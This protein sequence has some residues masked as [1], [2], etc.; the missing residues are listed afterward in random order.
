MIVL[1]PLLTAGLVALSVPQTGEMVLEVAMHTYR[2][3]DRRTANAGDSSASSDRTLQG[4]VWSNESLCSVAASGTQPRQA[5]AVGWRFSGRIVQRL[6][7]EFFVEVDWQRVWDQSMRLVGGPSGVVQLTLRAG[8]RLEL[9]RVAPATSG[10][11]DVTSARL[12]VAVVPRAMPLGPSGGGTGGGGGAGGR[13]GGTGGGVAS[14]H[15][16]SPVASGSVVGGSASVA[17]A[18]PAVVSDFEAE[19]WL[20]HR[21]PDGV[22]EVM[23]QSVTFG[24]TP[25]VFSFS[26]IRV[27]AGPNSVAISGTLLLLPVTGA[28]RLFRVAIERQIKTDGKPDVSGRSFRSMVLPSPADV[29]SFELPS[30]Q[31]IAALDGHQF[32]IRLRVK[33]R[34]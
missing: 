4:Y 15:P 21:M 3:D 26:P 11:C 27:G 31:G 34:G 9:D 33:P 8:D 13:H 25:R 23:R 24:S 28:S 20:L 32:S 17:P 14:H 6:G 30:S 19:M 18:P 29:I 5:P 16:K 10:S 7:D 1:L 22:E 2:S 12:E